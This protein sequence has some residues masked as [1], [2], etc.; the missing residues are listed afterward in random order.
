M[1]SEMLELHRRVNPKEI[2]VGWYSTWTGGKGAAALPAGVPGAPPAL[3]SG[4]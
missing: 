2:L 1:F 4:N 3:V